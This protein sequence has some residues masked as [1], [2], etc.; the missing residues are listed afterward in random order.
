MTWIRWLWDFLAKDKRLRYRLLRD[1]VGPLYSDYVHWHQFAQA[2]G[3]TG[4]NW[5]PPR[6]RPDL[7]L[8]EEGT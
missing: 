1:V 5:R 8:E 7:E 2:F 3:E 4:G 6:E